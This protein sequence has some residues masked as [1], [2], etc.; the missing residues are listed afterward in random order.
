MS[1]DLDLT[2]LFRRA[3][4]RLMTLSKNDPQVA[5]TVPLEA[6]SQSMRAPGLSY[7]E[8]IA[9]ALSGYADRAALGIR[10]YE[11][12]P[13]ENGRNIRHYLPSFTTITYRELARRIEAV[14]S[15]W[16]HHP[17]HRVAPGEFVCLIAFTGAEMTAM[18]MACTYAQAI[19]VPVQA[20]LPATDMLDILA[21]TEPV[22]LVA[23]I[24]NLERAA[25]Y[26][27]RQTSV[28]SL[29]VI[30]ADVADDTERERIEYTRRNLAEAG[31]R[32]AL[33][34]FAEIVEYGARFDW[35]PLPRSE[36]G[37][38][39][40][41][42]LMYTSGSTGTPKGAMIH[43]AMCSQMWTGTLPIPA[44]HIA[45]APMNHFMGL[46]VV[47][48]TLAQGGTVYFTLKSDMS[49]LFEDIRIVRPTFMLFMPRVAEIVYQH[50]RSEVQ[51][52]VAEGV[53][54]GKADADVRAEMRNTYLGD[55]VVAGSVGSAPTAPEVQVFL[56]ECFDIA[57][58][59]GYSSTEASSSGLIAGGKVQRNV[60]IDYK[61]IDVPELGY[62]TTDRPYPRG[63]LLLK[64]R[65]AIKGYFKRPEATAA[66][67]DDEG[68]LHTGDV[69]EE[70]GPDQLFWVDRRNNVIKLSQAEYVAIGPLEMT[71][72]GHSALI[73]QIYIY[74]SSYRSFLLAVVVPDT[75]IARARLGH[76]ASPGELR[77][78]ALAELQQAARDAGLKSFEVPRDVLIELEPFTH[79]NGLLSSVRKPLRPKLKERYQEAL[80]AMYQE[81]DRQREEELALL[82]RNGSGLSTLD[83]VVGALKA[84]LGLAAIDPENSQSY[85]DLGGD[86]LGAVSLSLLFEEMFGVAVPASII[87]NPAG[88]CRRLA[89]Y[90]DQV[91]T[92]GVGHGVPSLATVHGTD[93]TT[94]RSSDL[95]LD[96]FLD[97]QSLIA[98]S[99]ADLPRAETR[100]V[101]LTGATGFL[102]RFLCLEW[103]EAL[104]KTGGKVICI[105]RAADAED[106]RTRLDEAIGTGDPVLT[107][108]FRMLAGRHLEMFAGD[109]AAP[110]LGL[111]DATFARLAEEVD[112]IVHPGALVNHLLSYK[113][114]F[115]PNVLG[116]AELIRLALS[117]RQK[118]FDYVS[119]F[120]VPLMNP[121]LAQAGEDMDVRLGAPEMTLRDGYA[122]GYGTSKWASE[123]LLREAHE[124]FGLPVTVY[125]PD[126]IMAHARFKGQINVPDMFTRLLFSLVVTGIAPE[127][128]YERQPDGGRSRAHYDGMPVDFLAAAMQQLGAQPYEGF[129]TFNT[130]SAHHDDGISLDTITD[131]IAAAGYPIQRIKNHADWVRRFAD[132]LRNLP[133]AQ[134]QHSSLSILGH[135]DHPHPAKPPVIRNDG[136]VAAVRTLPAGPDV[137]HLSSE[138]IRKYLDDM[139]LVG[140]LPRAARAT[141]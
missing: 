91:R 110:R 16:R 1:E 45:Y 116:T 3:Y 44:I 136:F 61:L 26:A 100:T 89:R 11:I 93:A 86:S 88:N 37:Q 121:A 134:R 24:D 114:L 60:V 68:W 55:R 64:S 43:E 27:Q 48:G 19:S 101:L 132:K 8:I 94:V 119:T 51:R 46:N 125:R 78:M 105:V 22:A 32:V 17:H 36:D 140:L 117:K 59:N 75:D 69:M 133:D 40:L 118:R 62:Y 90:I 67:F 52:R 70:R 2:V 72:L 113:H 5:G 107:E 112:Q 50:Y 82:R 120:G 10:A 103:M 66:I 123:V 65:L 7:R 124:Q 38:D 122:S 28:R 74:G 127:T 54:P 35:T 25:D 92:A 29:I 85:S 30:D 111:D 81:M 97:A 6:V 12:G 77:T 139:H 23:S 13:D 80:E 83:R 115:E 128:F 99:D 98:A 47:F 14:A 33:A 42:M 102:G 49:T 21:D 87:L 79:E 39:T 58:T 131:W 96:A 76:D 106:A 141:A 130:I 126:M 31:G 137:P 34:T 95:A 18:D 108:R 104:A 57:F 41:S 4:E 56:R 73:R 109:L 138:F 129:R 53:D 9:A 135:F 15:A 71:Y 20:N 63:E 84:N